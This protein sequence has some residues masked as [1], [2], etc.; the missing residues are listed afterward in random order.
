MALKGQDFT[1][2][3]Y[4]PDVLLA[5]K[6]YAGEALAGVGGGLGS[7][8]SYGD[9][10]LDDNDFYKTSFTFPKR[11]GVKQRFEQSHRDR[12]SQNSRRRGACMV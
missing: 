9:F 11:V 10:R 1:K 5:G 12:S 3:A 4:I 7:F 6:A 2:N 8:M